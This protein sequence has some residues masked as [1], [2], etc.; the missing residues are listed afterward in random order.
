MA[1][2]TGIRKKQGCPGYGVLQQAGNI[3]LLKTTVPTASVG[4]PPTSVSEPTSCGGVATETSLQFV[5]LAQ[6]TNKHANASCLIVESRR[7]TMVQRAGRI[8][9][10]FFYR[11]F[12]LRPAKLTTVPTYLW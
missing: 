4:L 3:E 7:C 5:C 12:Q 1:S 2:T 11:D 6:Q 10:N 9:S 8:V